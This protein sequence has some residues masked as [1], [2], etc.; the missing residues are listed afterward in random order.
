MDPV[1]FPNPQFKPGDILV[2]A[3]GVACFTKGKEYLIGP[4]GCITDDDGDDWG[5][6]EIKH[7]TS[8]TFFR[9]TPTRIEAAPKPGIDVPASFPNANFK[10]G[11][12]LT[13]VSA[14]GCFTVGKEYDVFAD[15]SIPDDDLDKWGG[16]HGCSGT[17]LSTFK[18]RE[19]ENSDIE[20]APSEDIVNRPSHYTRW[21]IE[22]V[23][24]LMRNRVEGHLFNIVKY[25]MRAGYKLYPGKDATESE[26]TDLEKVIRYS[27]MRIN[28]LKGADK[29]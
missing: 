27:Q 8:S 15:G 18:V 28:L 21:A 13:C 1:T 22:P 12:V 25:A 5:P 26:I 11:D 29:L 16:D 23:E 4:G 9:K 3:K 17:T 14:G 10:P 7:D 24:F 20:E 6:G 19:P 2:C